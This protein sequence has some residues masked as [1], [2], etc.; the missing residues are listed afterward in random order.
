MALARR[1]LCVAGRRVETPTSCQTFRLQSLVTF[2]S[3]A[4]GVSAGRGREVLRFRDLDR[5]G[6]LSLTGYHAPRCEAA[7]RGDRSSQ[8]AI[9]SY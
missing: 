5:I 1:I 4:F 2:C 8:K 7:Q 9:T 3:Q 6:F